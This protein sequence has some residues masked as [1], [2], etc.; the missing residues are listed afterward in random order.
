MPMDRPDPVPEGEKSY[1]WI[2]S[3]NYVGGFFCSLCLNNEVVYYAPP[4]V[5]YMVGWNHRKVME[6]CLMKGW[7]A[8]W[9]APG[10]EL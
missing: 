4:I 10:S 2:D 7:S 1:I 8:E 5:D 6:Y 9:E 3:E